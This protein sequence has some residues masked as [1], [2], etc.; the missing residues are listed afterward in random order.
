MSSLNKWVLGQLSVVQEPDQAIASPWWRRPLPNQGLSGGQD[1][2]LELDA[3]KEGQM[4]RVEGTA[5]TETCN[6][7]NWWYVCAGTQY[8]EVERRGRWAAAGGAEGPN[9]PGDLGFV[10]GDTQLQ[11]WPVAHPTGS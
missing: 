8:C 4:E 10:P 9:R 3:Q 11:A 5:C 1:S 6:A 2:C 7:L